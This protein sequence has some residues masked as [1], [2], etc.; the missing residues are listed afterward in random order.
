[1]KQLRYFAA[2]WLLIGAIALV[3]SDHSTARI[4]RGILISGTSSTAP[5]APPAK[6]QLNPNFY[7]SGEYLTTNLLRYADYWTYATGGTPALPTDLDANGYPVNGAAIFTAGS[8]AVTRINAVPAQ[9]V[10]PGNYV[11]SFAGRGT[12]LS[13]DQASG[14]STSAGCVGTASGTNNLQCNN[15][16][17]TSATGSISGATLTI[18]AASSCSLVV[19][20]PITSGSTT[21]EE[22]GVPTIIIGKSGSANCPTCTGAGG[23]GTYLVN[24]SQTVVSGALIPGHRAEITIPTRT[25]TTTTFASWQVRILST[26]ATNP[27]IYGAFYHIDDELTYA[28][29]QLVS[30]KFRERVRQGGFEV[31]RDLNLGD[32]NAANVST[33]STRKPAKYFSFP[34]SELR[35]SIFYPRAQVTYALNGSSNDYSVN[36][37]AAQVDKQTVCIQ[38]PTTATNGTITLS[39]DNGA[40]KSTVRDYRGSPLSASNQAQADK[41]AGFVFDAYTNSWISTFISNHSG[42]QNCLN[43]YIPPEAFLRIISEIGTIRYPWIVMPMLASDPITD[44]PIQY[45]KY[46]QTNYPALLGIFETTNEP[47]NCG[48]A[49]TGAYASL[50]SSFYIAASSA[51][52]SAQPGHTFCSPFATGD[53]QNWIGKT[54]SLLG[55]AIR[56]VSS[57]YIVTIG[58][59]LVGDGSSGW[60]DTVRSTAYVNQNPANIPIQSGCAGAASVQTSC[61]T[62][63]TQTAAYQAMKGSTSFGAAISVANYWA[64]GDWINV[65]AYVSNPA[66]GNLAELARAWCYFY[67]AGGCA[68]QASLITASLATNNVT[69][70]APTLQTNYGNWYTFASTCA[71]GSS[72]TPMIV[73]NYEGTF[74]YTGQGTDITVTSTS[75][76]SSPPNTTFTF[77]INPNGTVVEQTVQVTAASNGTWSSIVNNSYVINAVSGANFTIPLDSSGLGTLTSITFTYTNSANYL[78]YFRNRILLDAGVGTLTTTL[79]D[80]IASASGWCAPNKCAYGPSQFVLGST[81]STA[82]AGGQGNFI[83]WSSDLYGYLV[84]ATC[85]LCS[86]SGA[87]LTLGGT[88][89]G[90]FTPGLALMG[91]GVNLQTITGSCSQT[92]S[93]PAGSNAGDV[94]PISASMAAT[95]NIAISGNTVPGLNGLGNSTTSP[96]KQWGAVCTWNGNSNQCRRR[97]AGGRRPARRRQSAAMRGATR[98]RRRAA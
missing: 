75:R 1:M 76:S 13:F 19:G 31:L 20:Q 14:G 26:D 95:S 70:S 39:L 44:W 72:C 28:S 69:V 84:Q 64:T 53:T 74:S 38:F 17:C 27:L 83:M 50:K 35:S 3:S 60:N 78:N 79:Y 30:P 93:G 56:S 23:T 29:G 71:G 25:E 21:V 7:S 81:L 47:W 42:G 82:A 43:N 61:P 86:V 6:S 40:T 2:Y 80:G 4:V 67:Q 45:A 98:R 90:I 94:C 87:N 41:F 52:S 18:T 85:T 92:G 68:S 62:P 63:F 32:A 9:A 91:Q 8:G 16:A 46:M 97:S 66:T 58:Q 34:T 51:W 96:A 54:A 59:Q 11:V 24:F 36:T 12:T 10:R 57:T 65:N 33:W 55:Q 89:T 48:G 88:I 37:G 73:L 77:G 15:A 5:T 49:G 22:F